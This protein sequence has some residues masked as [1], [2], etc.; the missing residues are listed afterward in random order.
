MPTAGPLLN[1][2]VIKPLCDARGLELWEVADAIGVQ[3][4]HLSN[5]VAGKRGLSAAALK[6]LADTLRVPTPALLV[7]TECATCGASRA[8]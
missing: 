6:R 8:S 3:P 4:A 7:I 1:H 2:H 5:V